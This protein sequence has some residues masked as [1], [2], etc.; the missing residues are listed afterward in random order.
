[1]LKTFT[2]FVDSVDLKPLLPTVSLID[3]R[4]NLFGVIN[5]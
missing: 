2:D 3:Y 1:V 4:I 5:N